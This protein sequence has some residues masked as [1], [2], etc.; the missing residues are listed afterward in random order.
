MSVNKPQFFRRSAKKI[1]PRLTS[2]Y[3]SVAHG[4]LLAL[5]VIFLGSG[6]LSGYH[7]LKRH[8][9]PPPALDAQL[10]KP[11]HPHLSEAQIRKMLA[12]TYFED[13]FVYA[14]YTGF[15]ERPRSGSFVSVSPEGFRFNNDKSQSISGSRLKKIC[16]FGG[17]TVFGYGVDDSNTITAHLQEI[18]NK[19]YPHAAYSVFNF[20]RGF[21]YSGQESI[22]FQALIRDGVRCEIAIFIDGV[23]EN[24]LVPNFTD[25]QQQLF[26]QYNYHPVRFFLSGLE[27]STLISDISRVVGG[28]PPPR[29]EPPVSVFVDGYVRSRAIIQHLGAVSATKAIFII[30]PVPGFRNSFATFK[31]QSSYC[32]PQLPCEPSSLARIPRIESMA[33]L[34]D[35]RTTHDFTGIFSDTTTLPFLDDV[36]YTPAA[37]RKIAEAIAPLLFPTTPN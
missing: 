37:N 22:L 29:P 30:Q 7:V 10:L 11:V 31:F 13:P 24:Q 6:M 21:Y 15:K 19:K 9:R 33:K 3:S 14:A 34:A 17:S 8:F 26:S 36:H 16:I 20:G 1:I 4:L 35:G 2:I 25:R 27:R 5:L 28:S 23:N 12:E 18:L 32:A